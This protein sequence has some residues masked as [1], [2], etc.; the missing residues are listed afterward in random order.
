MLIERDHALF[1]PVEGTE[2]LAKEIEEKKG[3]IVRAHDTQH[4]T[5]VELRIEECF[6]K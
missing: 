5:S 6:D 3:R 1:V 2:T 4:T